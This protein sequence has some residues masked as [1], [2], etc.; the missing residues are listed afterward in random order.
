MIGI[1]KITNLFTGESYIGQSTNL[2]RR[3]REHRN[4]SEDSYIDNAIFENGAEITKD[5]P[6]YIR[7]RK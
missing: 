4:S 1:Y 3:L 2:E 7:V 5:N 6:G